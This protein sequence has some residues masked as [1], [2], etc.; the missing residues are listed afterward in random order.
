[1]ASAERSMSSA[2]VCQPDT[3]TR[4]AARPA[5]VV[6]PSQH[7]PS[8]WTASMTARVRASPAAPVRIVAEAVEP[9]EDLVQ[10][11]LVEIRTPGPPPAAA[12]HLVDDPHSRAARE[13]PGHLMGQGAA[14]H[15]GVVGHVGL[16]SWRPLRATAKTTDATVTARPC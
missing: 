4:M 1:M 9:D 13:T 16:P 8:R 14:E 12:I 11:D 15:A 5:H 6:P 10:D 3:E 2:V 7:V